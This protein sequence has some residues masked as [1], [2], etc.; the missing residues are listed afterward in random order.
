[1]VAEVIHATAHCFS[2][3][4]RFSMAHGGKDGHPFPVSLAVYD[5]TITVLKQAVA[6][7]RLGQDER[8]AAIKRLDVQSRQ[9]EAAATGPSLPSY[10]AQERARAPKHGGRTV[11]DNQSDHP[12]PLADARE[13][14]PG[15]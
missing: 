15:R 7:A 12:D 9:L 3:P 8:L 13:A 14:L 11:F 2:D 5:R 1:M 6:S 4:A 10:M